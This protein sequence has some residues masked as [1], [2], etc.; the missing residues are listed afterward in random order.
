M[1]KSIVSAITADVNVG[2]DEVVSVFVSQYEDNLFAKKK[3]L[4]AQIK[5]LK[6][7]S[8]AL[9][10]RLI[11]SIDTSE[12]DITVPVLNLTSKVDNIDIVWKGDEDEDSYSS[13]KVKVSSVVVRVEVKDNDDNDRYSSSLN[14]NIN[15]TI[16]AADEKLHR[17]LETELSD[18]NG[19]LVEVMGLIKSVSRKERQVRGRISAKKLEESGFEG[20]LQS[21]EML[22]LIELD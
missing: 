17:N 15:V 10:T 8:K 5:Q 11:K 13:R 6:S 1:S 16:S 20:L 4:S 22:K 7:D 18:T 14:K 2:I 3:D 21:P 12:Y 9:D 19:E